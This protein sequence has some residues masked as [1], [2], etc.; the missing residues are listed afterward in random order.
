M[1]P[2]Q[3]ISYDG[4]LRCY[5]DG[6]SML[7]GYPSQLVSVHD[8]DEYLAAASDAEDRS[9]RLSDLIGAYQALTELRRDGKV[10][11]V[12]VGAKNWQ[13]IKELDTDCDFD[14]VMMANSY[15]IMHHPDD[16][17]QFVDSLAARNVAIINSAVTHG[18][19][20]T[21]GSLFSIIA[22]STK[23]GP[24]GLPHACVGGISL[25]KSARD[26]N[27][28]PM[29]S[30]SRSAQRTPHSMQWRSARVR[31]NELRPWS[32]QRHKNYRRKFGTH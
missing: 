31:P 16:L 1:T 28:R 21:G 14:W 3:D 32:L 24:N 10:S 17:I 11:G 9:N 25:P 27:V 6:C 8:P 29:K 7:G 19:F 26:T 20:L 30:Q 18:G 5:E 15:T 13:S 22:R 4:I 23:S 12:G 2:F